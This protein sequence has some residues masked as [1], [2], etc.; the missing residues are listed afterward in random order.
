MIAQPL[1]RKA[2]E[3]NE[4]TLTEEEAL[5][6]IE[7]SMRVLFYRDARSINKVWLMQLVALS[8]SHLPLVPSGYDYREGRHDLGV[9]PFGN[10][11]VVCRG[12]Q[13]LRVTNA[14]NKSYK[15]SRSR[16]M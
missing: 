3:G 1:L 5:K 15:L 13:R 4:T 7:S 10:I 2:V 11:L 16:C 14:I 8:I 9:P 12:N 6:I